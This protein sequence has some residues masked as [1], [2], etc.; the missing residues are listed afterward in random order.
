MAEEDDEASIKEFFE[1]GL[2]SFRAVLSWLVVN[3]EPNGRDFEAVI[4]AGVF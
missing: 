3:V 4:A 1:F 2:I